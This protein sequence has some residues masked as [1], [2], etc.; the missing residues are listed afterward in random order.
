VRQDLVDPVENLLAAD[1]SDP[2][3]PERIA[4][5]R[6][7][8]VEAVRRMC[9]PVSWSISSGLPNADYRALL[10]EPPSTLATG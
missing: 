10:M 3:S 9:A 1:G 6:A 4:I 8:V 2:Q 7:S 5:H